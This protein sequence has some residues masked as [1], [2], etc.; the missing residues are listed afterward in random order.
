MS[1]E[2]IE[3][4]SGSEPGLL[5]GSSESAQSAVSV[6]KIQALLG[7]TD[8][9]LGRYIADGT[10]ISGAIEEALRNAQA[11]TEVLT[12]LDRSDTP[13]R[14]P[15]EHWSHIAWMASGMIQRAQELY[16]IQISY[17]GSN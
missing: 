2:H 14:V 5:E 8:E 15:V 3:S 6:Y 10:L 9:E 4:I 1:N 17:D 7:A 12:C 16:S 11:L 13:E